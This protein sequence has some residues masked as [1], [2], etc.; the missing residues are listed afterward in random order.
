[1]ATGERLFLE[2]RGKKTK[3]AK[4]WTDF[5]VGHN[6]EIFPSL[7]QYLRDTPKPIADWYSQNWKL[8]TRFGVVDDGRTS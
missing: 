2:F 3:N 7:C 1:M 6:F 5:L 8:F 4:S